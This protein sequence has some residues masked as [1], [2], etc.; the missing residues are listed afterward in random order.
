MGISLSSARLFVASERP[1]ERDCL[2]RGVCGLPNVY[3]DV[4]LSPTNDSDLSNFC[5]EFVRRGIRTTIALSLLMCSN[6]FV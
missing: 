3:C 5:V 1:L 2:L 4:Q 6:P